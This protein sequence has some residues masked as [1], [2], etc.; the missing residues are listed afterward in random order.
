MAVPDHDN[1]FE[2]SSESGF[3]DRFFLNIERFAY[4]HSIAVVL[5]SLFIAGL[6]V[7]ITI[8]KLSFKKNRGDLVEKKTRL[9][10]K[11]RKIPPGI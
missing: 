2:I 6:S 4:T 7:W 8:E 10:G 9:R 1:N 11:L 3:L 5:V